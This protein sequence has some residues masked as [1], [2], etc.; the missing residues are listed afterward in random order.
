MK[1]LQPLGYY[2]PTQVLFV[3][4]DKAL[5]NSLEGLFLKYFKIVTENEAPAALERLQKE[6]IY[7]DRNLI[8]AIDDAT[9][10]EEFDCPINIHISNIAKKINNSSREQELSVV[11]VDYRM[12]G[13]TGLEL[14]EK[15]EGLPIKKILLTGEGEYTLAIEAFN[16]G[17]IDH[18]ISKKDPDFLTNLEATIN[19]LQQRYFLERTTFLLSAA[20]ATPESF[21][22][23]PSFLKEFN[24]FLIHYN[25][26]EFFLLD[27]VGSFVGLN[28][29][30]EPFWFLVRNKMQIADLIDLAKDNE[31]STP[32]LDA[33]QAKECIIYFLTEEERNIEV[34]KWEQLSHPITSIV[35]DF[36]VAWVA[37]PILGFH[38]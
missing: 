35:D 10:D 17:I 30:G 27:R 13:M 11:V 9:L 6:N 37:G 23:M 14:C 28:Y 29:Q 4:D 34:A 18:Y 2:Y 16:N 7:L 38:N 21:L 3:D 31:Y 12:P 36:Y 5:L 33:L 25:I 1:L 20:R 32:I 22:C 15:L 24:R 26:V 8:E 19:L